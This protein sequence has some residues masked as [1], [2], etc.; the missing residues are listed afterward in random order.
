M[1]RKIECNKCRGG[2]GTVLCPKCKGR[3]KDSQGRKCS[4]CDGAGIV[5]CSKCKGTGTIEVEVN[6]KWADMGW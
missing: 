3:E 1:K 4:Y 5:I 2:S 6:D